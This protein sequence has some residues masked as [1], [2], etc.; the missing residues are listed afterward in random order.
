MGSF[1]KKYLSILLLIP[2][3]GGFTQ[4]KAQCDNAV[5]IRCVSVDAVGD[6]TLTWVNPSN[7]ISCGWQNFYVEVSTTGGAGTYSQLG[8]PILNPGQTSQLIL[9]S[10]LPASPLTQRLYFYII[11]NNSSHISYNSDTVSN[12]FL[13]SINNTSTAQLIWN[14]ISSPLPPASSSWYMIYREYN[15][16]WTLIDSTQNTNY[17]D[18]ITY[19]QNTFLNYQVTI[20]DSTL[21]IS[22]SNIDTGHTSYHNGIPPPISAMDTVSVSG[23]NLELSWAKSQKNQVIGY[24]ILKFSHTTATYN[25]FAYVLGV[26]TTHFDTTADPSDSVYS[27]EIEAFDSCYKDGAISTAQNNIHLKVSEDRCAQENTLNWNSFVDL[28]GSIGGYR[29]FYSVNNGPFQILGTTDKSTT[30]Y[31]DS[32]LYTREYRCYYIQVYDSARR[33]TTASSNIVCDSIVP[34]PRPK[35]DYLRTATVLLNTSSIQIVGYVDSTSG[36]VYYA[37]QRSDSASGFVTVYKMTATHHTDSISYIDNSVNP[38]LRSYHYQ[39]ITLDSCDKPIDSSNIGQTMLLKAVGYSNGTN[40]LTWNDYKDWYAGPTQ[41]L[42][43]RSED[44][45]NYTLLSPPVTY[46]DAGQNSFTDNITGI[47]AGQGTFYYYV[48]AIENNSA[49]YYPYTD[50]SYS[51]IAKAYQD[52]TVFIPDAFSPNGVNRIFK[53]EGVF[54]DVKG[55]DF[56]ILNRWGDVL[57]ESTNPEI[58]WNGSDKGGKIVQEGVY[59]YL[60]TFTSS[61]G[62]YFQSKGTVTLLK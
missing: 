38:V 56:V 12:I 32:N 53:P 13:Y 51:N 45:I 55:Y 8:A 31:I 3:L 25:N 2:L 20:A 15:N 28:D 14:P 50:T 60:L 22:N 23:N 1:I 26:N 10:S 11:T 4:V 52:P 9:A 19:C 54:I 62:E 6:I 42:I 29:V 47:T 41:Y 21:C 5:S 57:F 36:A 58:G 46:T 39:I 34:A 43:Y 37:F 59:V 17:L 61:K 16:S 49:A 40:V 7:L 44:G 30:T 18:T 48:K 24:R 27:F 33:D 35:N